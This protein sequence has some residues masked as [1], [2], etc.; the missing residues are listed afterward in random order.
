MFP[1]PVVETCVDYVYDVSAVTAHLKSVSGDHASARRPGGTWSRLLPPPLAYRQRSACLFIILYSCEA[2][3][4]FLD[5]ISAH[6]PEEVRGAI[7][8]LRGLCS[9]P[10]A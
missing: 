5:S 7:A 10:S 2:F 8:L 6:I 9:G 4:H 1:S 3:A